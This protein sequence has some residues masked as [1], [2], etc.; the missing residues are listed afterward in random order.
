MGLKIDYLERSKQKSHY[1][2]EVLLIC[3]LV[4]GDLYNTRMAKEGFYQKTT[5]DY[6]TL[7]SRLAELALIAKSKGYNL[8][9]I[10]KSLEVIILIKLLFWWQNIDLPSKVVIRILPG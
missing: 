10:C 1:F 4:L 7:V 5:G 2:A 3:V 8:G 9:V 6:Y